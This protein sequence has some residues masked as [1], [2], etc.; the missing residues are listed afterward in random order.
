MA[1]VIDID[2]PSKGKRSR[3]GKP[4]PPVPERQHADWEIGLACNSKGA[5]RACLANV[6]HV[7]ARHPEWH[8]VLAYDAFAQNV[9]TRKQPPMRAQDAPSSY[10]IGDWGDADTVRTAA[11]M[12]TE[13]G[14]DAA[15]SHV[16]SAVN[17]IAQK[18][19]VHPVRDWLASLE[20]DGKQR[21]PSLLSRYFGAAH[22]PYTSAVGTRWMV[23][24][25][26]RV[27]EPGAKADCMVVLESDEQ[28]IGKSSALRILASPAWFADTGITIGEKDSYQSLR[29]KWIYEFAE[30]AAIKSARDVE[31]VKNFLSSQCD[32]FRASYGHRTQDYP[33]QV[34]FAGSTNERAYLA[35]PTGARRFWPV[36]CSCIDLAALERDRD[37][38][39]AEARVRYE[40]REPWHLDTPELRA[41]A[42]SEQ[43]AREQHDDW[44]DLVSRWLEAPTVP[45]PGSREERQRVELAD[46]FTTLDVQLGAIGL[47][48]DKITSGT[49]ARV[50]HVLRKLGFEPDQ[51]RVPGDSE[52]R[53]R[54]YFRTQVASTSDGACDT[55]DAAESLQSHVTGVTGKGTYTRN[56]EGG[57]AHTGSHVAKPG[58]TPETCDAKGPA[59]DTERAE[60]KP[61]SHV[62]GDLDD[63]EVKL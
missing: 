55:S 29:R 20:W 42:V 59:R 49:N 50:G 18:V 14:I 45:T 27:H 60:N 32:T 25:V 51:R 63:S 3:A 28:G 10:E 6:M 35:D 21:L 39:W 56:E 1:D 62:T 44:L 38:L 12:T 37:Q 57:D 43:T 30:L 24:A 58:G 47:T 61:P 41:L 53:R 26:A 2:T 48:P 13:V 11:W 17:T 16:D 23:S 22:V 15:P 8:G 19:I 40:S 34:V 33:R 36:R 4:R 31:R 46:G 54:L 5:P 9:I 52:R 7:L